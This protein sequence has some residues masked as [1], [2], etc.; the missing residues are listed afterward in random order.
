[1]IETNT[2]L[3]EVIMQQFTS[4]FQEFTTISA[5]CRMLAAVLIG[6]VIGLER[7][8]HGKA[9]GFRTHVLVCLGASITAI[10]GL[11]VT[12]VLGSSG[13]PMRLSAQVISGIGF[14]GAGSILIVGK[15]HIRGITTAA[16]LWVTAA[17]GLGVGAGFIVIALAGALIV[18]L[19][20]TVM[21]RLESSSDVI[22]NRTHYY[23]E[24]N[25][26][27]VTNEI[28]DLLREKYGVI[29]T[30]IVPARSGISGNIG[31]EAIVPFS[32]SRMELPKVS[33]LRET[34]KY[35]T[36]AVRSW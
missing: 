28:V 22:G 14:L 36:V 21:Y 24:L 34:S 19:T 12:N 35:V 8:R 33:E 15:R 29:E 9:A 17:I 26:S 20:M 25:D 27:S 6:G 3:T 32:G 11:Y 31:I 10:V 18:V 1:M 13:D 5:I 2:T 16:G 23:V 7:G 4:F 30:N